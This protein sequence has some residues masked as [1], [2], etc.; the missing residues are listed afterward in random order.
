M[1]REK[2]KKVFIGID[3]GKLENS[4]SIVCLGEQYPRYEFSVKNNYYGFNKIK[5]CIDLVIIE[6]G[7]TYDECIIGIETTGNYGF[8][9]SKY[10]IKVG[11]DIVIVSGIVVK[12]MKYVYHDVQ[13]KNDKVDAKVISY[14]LR[15]K[16]YAII[17]PSVQR[18]KELR[19][20]TR[21]LNTMKAAQTQV[22]NRLHTWLEEGNQVFKVLEFEFPTK[23]TIALLKA[24][25]CVFD[26]ENLELLEVIGMLKEHM[27]IPNRRQV[28]LYIEEC[29]IAREYSEPLSELKRAELKELLCQYDFFE[30][31]IESLEKRI[32]GIVL[33]IDPSMERFLNKKI[34]GM[35]ESSFFSIL[36]ETNFMKDFESSRS[37]LN[38]CGLNLIG[39]AS[40]KEKGKI[41]ISRKGSK[42]IR[43]EAFVLIDSFIKRNR[44]IRRL[45]CYYK[46]Y[47]R[48]KDISKKAMQIATICK[49]LR[50][51]YGAIKNNAD[52]DIK[53][54]LE[55]IDF[56]KCNKKK[57]REEMKPQ[58]QRK[59]Q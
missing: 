48:E 29:E 14:C 51:F 28:H 50:C 6:E 31:N 20:L 56:D 47:E 42:H 34:D 40:G 33:D 53:K 24:V 5:E 57:F 30:L 2:S 9:L 59:Y 36:A 16:H 43:K 39:K 8:N 1:A 54:V 13:D 17:K 19:Q 44:D 22:I 3:I 46:S 23:T 15:D 45:Y 12:K 11:L 37:L 41:K 32:K 21:Q 26:V 58:S 52:F 38:Y 25:P 27:K 7:C 35:V 10:M 49:I 55:P 4:V 18:I